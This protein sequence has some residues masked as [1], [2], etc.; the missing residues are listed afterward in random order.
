[1]ITTLAKVKERL[2]LSTNEHDALLTQ[3]ILACG[4]AFARETGRVLERTAVFQQEFSAGTVEVALECYPLEEISAWEMKR[5][6][7]EGWFAIAPPAHVVRRGCVVS[8]ESPLGIASELVRITYAAGYVMPP[9]VP[10]TG[11][12]GFPSALE[13]A[14]VEQIAFW[15]QNREHVGMFRI[16]AT[17]G[18]YMEVADRLWVPWVRRTLG[19]FKRMS[20]S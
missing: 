15:F 3:L 18:E 7:L 4:S 1:M 13:A 19:G 9:A 11:Q 8:L 14:A 2:A 10:G 17:G 5:S 20:V 6:E 16:E 12:T